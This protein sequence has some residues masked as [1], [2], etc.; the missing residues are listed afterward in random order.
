MIN[1]DI[2]YALFGTPV[3]NSF[4]QLGKYDSVAIQNNYS[5]QAVGKRITFH[6]LEREN[7]LHVFGFQYI[8][9][10]QRIHINGDEFGQIITIG[11]LCL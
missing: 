11:S 9:G 6:V 2:C 10:N 3:R 4:V 1:E 5:R 7:V 8:F